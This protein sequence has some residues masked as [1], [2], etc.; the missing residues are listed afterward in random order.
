MVTPAIETA[1]KMLE[2]LPEE[3]Q[4]RA[5]EHLREWLATVNEEAE[6]DQTFAKPSEK[7]Y[8]AAKKARLQIAEGKAEKMDFDRL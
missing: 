2:S 6:W 3:A 1:L 5:V 8:E 4:T 7:L